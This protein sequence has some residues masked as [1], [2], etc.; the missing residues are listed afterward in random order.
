MA[1]QLKEAG[2]EV[3]RQLGITK[4]SATEL[5]FEKSQNALLKWQTLTSPITNIPD[6]KTNP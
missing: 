2:D 1:R 3:A 4:H 5:T 6:E